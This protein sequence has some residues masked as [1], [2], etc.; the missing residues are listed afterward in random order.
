MPYTQ[1]HKRLLIKSPTLLLRRRLVSSVVNE[2]RYRTLDALWQNLLDLLG[3]NRV[4]TVVQCVCL[5][6]RLAGGAVGGVKL[7]KGY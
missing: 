1:R 2:V 3:D 5:G 6:G 7:S 4:L